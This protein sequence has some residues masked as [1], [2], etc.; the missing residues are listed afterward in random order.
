MSTATPAEDTLLD[1]PTPTTAGGH[2]HRDDGHHDDGH[3]D[4]PDYVA[5]HFDS[6]QQQFDAGKLGIWLFLAQEVLFFSGLFCFYAYYKV[7]HPE[8]FSYAHQF[9]DI[10]YGA[11]N[12]VVL[13]TSSLTMAWGVRAAQLN[14]K[15]LLKWC[16]GATIAGAFIFLGIKY[17]EYSHKL[18]FGMRPGRMYRW[19][20]FVAV[21][22][23]E[24]RS[25]RIFNHEDHGPFYHLEDID[26]ETGEVRPGAIPH[27][28]GG[29]A[30][31]GNDPSH[32]SGD[33]HDSAD[34]PKAGEG[35][36]HSSD[37]HAA[38]AREVAGG[39][40]GDGEPDGP[41]TAPAASGE[42]PEG[43]TVTDTVNMARDGDAASVDPRGEP[44]D[45]LL[46]D[47]DSPEVAG[48][49]IAMETEAERAAERSSD[50]N[51][52]NRPEEAGVYF[53]LYYAMTGLHAIHIIAGIA[54]LAWLFVRSLREEFHSDYFGPVDYVGL[55]WHLVDLIWIF[56]FPM[57]YLFR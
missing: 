49:G 32:E 38:T 26:P 28:D 21:N 5:H 14:Q 51:E 10:K 16:L 7:L 23:G 24:E 50:V 47:S 15:Q 17:V 46:I 1:A 33:H 43:A 4:H 37:V 22:G 19:N 42:N 48:Q 56:L 20:Q 25:I 11:I 2:G 34:A 6:S 27:S 35:T 36:D 45:G 57:L 9:L 8:A 3:G 13:I 29:H 52:H 53:S 40:I 18:H 55:Y 44:A 39:Q 31:D 54:V 12:T 41:V 30:E